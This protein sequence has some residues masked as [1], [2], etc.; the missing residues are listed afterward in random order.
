[1]EVQIIAFNRYGLLR[2]I[3]TVFSNEK[4]T[5]MAAHGHLNKDNHTATLF[6]TFEIPDITTLNRALARIQQLLDVIQVRRTLY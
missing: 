5:V 3:T 2:G 1:M 6:I 4:L